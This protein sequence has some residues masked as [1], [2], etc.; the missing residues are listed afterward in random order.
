MVKK[1]FRV[2]LMEHLSKY[3]KYNNNA[4]SNYLIV[5]KILDHLNTIYQYVNKN[6]I[7]RMLYKLIK[8]FS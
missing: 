4:I 6:S 3:L 7:T 5:N 1:N 8:Q 2:R